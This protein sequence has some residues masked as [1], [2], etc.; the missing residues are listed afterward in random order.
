MYSDNASPESSAITGMDETLAMA[1]KADIQDAIS[2]VESDLLPEAAK[3]TKFY[4]AEPFGDEEEGRSAVVQPVVR[5]V[6]RA[7]LPSLMRIFFGGQRVVE[8]TGTQ[9]MSAEYADEMTADVERVFMRE[10]P[11]FLIAYEAFKDALIR[12]VGWITWWWDESHKIRSKSYTGVSMDQLMLF[13]SVKTESESVEILDREEI[14]PESLDPQTGQPIPAEYKFTVRIVQKKKSGKIMVEAVPLDEIIISRDARSPYNARLIGRRCLKTVGELRAMGIPQELIDEAGTSH[15]QLSGNELA[16]TRDPSSMPGDQAATATPDQRKLQYIDVSYVIDQDGD[17]I[18]E[19]RRI[20][21]IGDNYVEVHNE[22]EDEVCFAAFC[23]D[24]EPHTWVGLSTT[25]NVADLQLVGSHVLR[26]MLDSFKLSI[27]PRMEVVEGQ[28]NIDDVLNTE[29]GAAIRVRQKGVVTPI[30]TPFLGQQ[31]LPM[32]EMLNEQR[33]SRT[34]LSRN[35]MGL[36]PKALQSTNPIA[37]AATVTASHA[38]PELIARIFAETGMKR[39]YRGIAKMVVEKLGVHAIHMDGALKKINPARWDVDAELKVDTGLGTG[40]ND[41]KIAVLRQTANAQAEVLE[42]LGLENPLCSMQELYHTQ[43]KI[44][45][46]SGVNDVH[47]YWTNPAVKGP[48][49]EPQQPQPSPE[50]VLADAEM[51]IKAGELDLETLDLILK[52]DRERD[53]ME[54]NALL[55]VMEIE[56]TTGAQLDAAALKALQDRRRTDVQ[57]K[58]ASMKVK[59]ARRPAAK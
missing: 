33:E 44:L 19:R 57:A 23:P 35:A 7:T 15:D 29:I 55:K 14:A 16:R 18:S 22:Y 52:D 41:A 1:L 46:L 32:L 17:G 47:R 11:G 58:I 43:K 54:T 10:N 8:F 20:C 40:S 39:L 56:A 13:E 31:A 45:E 42:K 48:E 4:N 50:Q 21:A 24:P 59:Q 9:A 53:E 34:G 27:F 5:E 26:D 12:K 36:D 30:V 25:D 38:Q 49:L 3:A 37:V 6:V 28:A 51:K 2:F